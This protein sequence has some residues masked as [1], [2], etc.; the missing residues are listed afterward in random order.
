[1][2]KITYSPS[3]ATA[4]RKKN[5]LT[6]GTRRA[7][8]GRVEVKPIRVPVDI[9]AQQ[10][11]ASMAIEGRRLDSKLIAKP[12]RASK[13]VVA[14]IAARSVERRRTSGQAPTA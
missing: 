2:K 10:V 1:M 3:I 12:T 13:Q 14:T 7:E 11:S 8:V 6:Q 5:A 4:I 9:I